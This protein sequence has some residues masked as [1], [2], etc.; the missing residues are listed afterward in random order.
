MKIE[1]NELEIVNPNLPSNFDGCRI[2]QISDLHN[3]SY[4][5]ENE[6]LLALLKNAHA[7]MIVITGDFIDS[8][9]TK[10][11]ISLKA[12][13]E[14]VKLA[15]TFY[16]PGN[17]ES[18]VV[19]EY[20]Y[21]KQELEQLGVTVLEN[22]SVEI[23]QGTDFITI[24]GLQ[25]PGFFKIYKKE[26]EKHYFSERLKEKRAGYQILL[27]HRPEHF[28]VYA[29]KA[30]LVFCGHAHGGQFIFPFFGGLI[31]PGQGLFPKYYK[32][33]YHKNGTDMVVSRGAGYTVLPLRINNKPEI[34]VVTLRKGRT[35]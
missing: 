4:G 35:A 10:P 5:K 17:H 24:T 15:P 33:V 2:A 9:N 31:A 26:E 20:E 28:D 27:V 3:M 25:D 29:G 16:I 14:L 34:V 23:K 18:R 30:D 22:K 11:E 8:R 21:L 7:D 6:R 1:L 19:V 12:A 32:G 13:Q